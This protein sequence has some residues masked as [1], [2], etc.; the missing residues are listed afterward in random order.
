MNATLTH[1]VSMFL[2][3]DANVISN[4]LVMYANRLTYKFKKIVS[5]DRLRRATHEL[6]CLV[7]I[8][9]WHAKFTASGCVCPLVI[10]ECIAFLSQIQRSPYQSVLRRNHSHGI[11]YTN[12]M[13]HH[14]PET[15]VQHP[16]SC[17]GPHHYNQ[18][19]NGFSEHLHCQTF[20]GLS[21]LTYD[22]RSTSMSDPK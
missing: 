14:Y 16:K 12:S 1:H 7:V 19:Q 18:I 3:N 6:C 17:S 10:T 13:A 21:R 2:V 15:S 22:N 11:V 20:R 9:E 5:Q 8:P 4:T